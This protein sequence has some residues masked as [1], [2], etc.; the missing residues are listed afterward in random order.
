MAPLSDR[1]HRELTSIRDTVESIWVAIVVALVL[2]AFLIEAFVI[3]TGSMAPEL[4]GEHWDLV[5]PACGFEYAYGGPKMTL[6]QA[7]TYRR[8]EP[9]LPQGAH[10][11]NCGSG[12]HDGK[13]FLSK[14]A[15]ADP[16]PGTPESLYEYLKADIPRW[17]EMF[18]LAK[19][20]PQ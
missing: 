9:Y 16:F 6:E 19:I 8:S 4:M 10:C 11:P 7:A 3:P 13:E 17:A 2:R 15:P 1:T 18:K 12:Y 14:T 5:C 20:A